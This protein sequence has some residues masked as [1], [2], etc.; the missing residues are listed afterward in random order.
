[1]SVQVSWWVLA[2]L[3][4]GATYLA[5][6]FGTIGVHSA[7]VDKASNPPAYWIMLTICGGVTVLALLGGLGLLG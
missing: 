7:A 2:I 5:F 1:M 6:R 4:G 3:F